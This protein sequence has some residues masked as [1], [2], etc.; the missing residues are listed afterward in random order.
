MKLVGRLLLYDSLSASVRAIRV[1]RDSECKV[2][3]I[4]IE[5]RKLMDSYD[6][7]NC[8]DES[9]EISWEEFFRCP[10]PLVDVREEWEF[11]ASPSDGMLIPLASLIERME[12]L[13]KSE[14]AI[15]CAVG[16][17]SLRAVSVLKAYGINA[18]S[19]RGGMQ[20]RNK[21]E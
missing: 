4:P 14:F 20:A 3:S 19:L 18:K 9:L 13:P 1:Q 11:A 16:V 6:F 12:E 2:C 15:V 17:R 10:M 21:F 7:D 5:E 8:R